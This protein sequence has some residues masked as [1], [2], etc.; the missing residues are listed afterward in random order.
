MNEVEYLI[1]RKIPEGAYLYT[2]EELLLP[3]L[4]IKN[5]EI[6]RVMMKW[7]EELLAY[8]TNPQKMIYNNK[9][10]FKSV[11]L[12]IPMRLPKSRLD[13][14][15][16]NLRTAYER[17]LKETQE[18]ER[19]GLSL[20]HNDLLTLASEGICDGYEFLNNREM[21]ILKFSEHLNEG[22]KS[23]V[24]E[25]LNYYLRELSRIRTAYDA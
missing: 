2:D 25:Y 4:E 15:V 22:L 5:P 16:G 14:L 23:Y 9:F 24:F 12:M 7:C 19:V 10:G 11:G 6:L 13:I 18:C 8:F 21:T 17:I 3:G 1:G 20:M